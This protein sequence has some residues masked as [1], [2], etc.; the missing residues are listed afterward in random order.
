MI[1]EGSEVHSGKSK[2]LE[3]IGLY[4]ELAESGRYDAIRPRMFQLD[5]ATQGREI[6]KLV[7]TPDYM[8]GS[9]A[10]VTEAGTLVVASATG[11]QLG[12]YASGAGRLILVVGSQKIVPDLD[13][14]LRRIDEV[15]F[16]YEDAQVVARLGVHTILEKVLLIYGEWTARQDHGRAGPRTRRRLGRREPRRAVGV[17][18]GELEELAL[19]G[20]P[21]QNMDARVL[22]DQA[23]PFQEV[24]G[25]RRD[26]DLARAGERHHP[27]GGM[28]RDAA[29]IW[30]HE[31]DLAR[32]EPDA[33]PQADLVG[34]STHGGATADGSRRAIEH[35]EEPIAGRGDLAPSEDIQLAAH[36]AVVGRQQLP[37]C[38]IADAIHRGRRIHDVGEEDRRQHAFSRSFRG[39]PERPGARPL[40][41]DPGRIADDP[42][43]V[44]SRDL[45]HRLAFDVD[46]LPIVHHDVHA[47]GDRIAEVVEL[48]G[49]RARDPR[50][51]RRPS[52]A[53]LVGGATDGGLVE[54]EEL[55]MAV[56]EGP[57]LVWRRKA[58]G[59]Q[60]GHAPMMDRSRHARCRLLLMKVR[61]VVLYVRDA[62]ACRRFW[63]EQVG[64]V[65]KQRDEIG[66][67]TI[68]QVGFADQPFAFE[69]VPLAMMQDNPDDLD[70]ATPSIAF[71]VDDLDAARAELVGRGVQATEVGDH[72]GTRSFAFSD[73]EGRWFAVTA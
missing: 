41:R 49:R 58:S 30:P 48:A 70:L 31:L 23:G 37:P 38:C 60:A 8:V 18:T 52:P 55:G 3:D 5:R 69:L 24:L 33:D 19:A 15:V 65:Q 11:S 13:A 22:E 28:D 27:G 57:H 36:E 59:L 40:D 50:H 32:M 26:D 4:A 10:A 9:V 73:P 12:A 47:A 63:V 64:M 20:Q 42:R 51:V 61:Y 44:A 56:L 1:P 6:R 21:L 34:G 67:F 71:Q 66:A 54:Q 62:D 16:P 25:R 72:Q 14:A 35:G 17:R 7:G 45:V 68:A 53:G 2:T 46:L 29:R 43:V 39:D